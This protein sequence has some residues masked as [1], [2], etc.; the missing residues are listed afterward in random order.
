MYCLVV[1]VVF[2]RTS[3]MPI[4]CAAESSVRVVMLSRWPEVTR[5]WMSPPSVQ[6]VTSRPSSARNSRSTALRDLSTP[7]VNTPP[8]SASVMALSTASETASTRMPFRA[9]MFAP[10]PTVARTALTAMFSAK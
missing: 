10:S 1:M 7:S 8:W 3:E 4:S 2:A 6:S 5:T 9:C